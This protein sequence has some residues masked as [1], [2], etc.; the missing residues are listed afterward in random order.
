MPYINTIDTENMM[1]I[2]ISSSV[3]RPYKCSILLTSVRLNH[4][5]PRQLKT[6]Q[7]HKDIGFIRQSMVSPGHE[8]VTSLRCRDTP[9]ASGLETCNCCYY[10]F[11]LLLLV[12][13]SH[14][15]AVEPQAAQAVEN[16]RLQ[17]AHPAGV[18]LHDH[19]KGAVRTQDDV[20]DH[21]GV[22]AHPHVVRSGNRLWAMIA[23]NGCPRCGEAHAHELDERLLVLEPSHR[24]LCTISQACIRISHM[25]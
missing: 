20:I 11:L 12:W 18:K 16:L 17:E 7:E 4:R 8:L 19:G 13:V 15:S 2:S 9:L 6:L 10:Y 21:G 1:I 23:D 22:V 25:G 3:P 24:V 5:Q 14:L